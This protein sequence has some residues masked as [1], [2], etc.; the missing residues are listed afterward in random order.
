V[1]AFLTDTLTGANYQW[2]RSSAQIAV[3]VFNII[4]NL[5]IIR[6]Y[7]WRGAAWSSL[8]TDSLFAV[9]LYMI[10]RRYL[11]QERAAMIAA[12]SKTHTLFVTG[13]E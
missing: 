6:A 11:R 2:Q 13:M 7:A 5:W 1:H 3:A 4:V 9:L 8:L 10:I 12:A